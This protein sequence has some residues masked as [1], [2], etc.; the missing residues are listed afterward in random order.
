MRHQRQDLLVVVCRCLGLE[1][2]WQCLRC[3]QYSHQGRYASSLDSM[4]R[5]AAYVCY[6]GM[7]SVIFPYAGSYMS[8]VTKNIGKIELNGLTTYMTMQ[9]HIGIAT[10]KSRGCLALQFPVAQFLFSVNYM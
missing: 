6:E 3:T 10:E 1:H 7:K 2:G 4:Y 9:V 5:H 8:I